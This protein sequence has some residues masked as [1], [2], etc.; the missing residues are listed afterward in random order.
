MTVQ[1][2]PFSAKR[3]GVGLGPPGS[4]PMKPNVTDMPGR[5]LAFHDRLFAVTVAP[6]WLAETLQMSR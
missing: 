1:A 2:P 6:L 5:I 3:P 4:V